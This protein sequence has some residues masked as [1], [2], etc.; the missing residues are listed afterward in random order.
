VEGC[1][2]LTPPQEEEKPLPPASSKCKIEI[3]GLETVNKYSGAVCCMFRKKPN[4][5]NI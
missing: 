4:Q 5:E 1:F 3:T 2:N